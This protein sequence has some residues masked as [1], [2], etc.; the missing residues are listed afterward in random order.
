M[1]QRHNSRRPASRSPTQRPRRASGNHGHTGS[2]R[3]VEAAGASG[4]AFDAC[5][6]S[7]RPDARIDADVA[8]TRA[9]WDET[10][11]RGLPMV[12]IGETRL[13]GLQTA[14]ELRAVLASA[15]AGHDAPR[16]GAWAFASGVLLA[17]GAFA[18]YARRAA[19]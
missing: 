15:V 2:D 9:V 10:A 13:L 17:W 3:A 12:F 14:D 18:A 6:A 7:A 8:W 1:W 5:L 4:A 16:W 11:V 19:R